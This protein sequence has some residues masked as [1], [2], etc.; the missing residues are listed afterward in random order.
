MKHFY[1]A[2]AA[3]AVLSL[4][5]CSQKI[6]I[7]EPVENPTFEIT[8]TVGSDDA[9]KTAVADDWSVSW[10]END[11]I[12]AAI[13]DKSSIKF[14]YS[15]G[16]KFTTTDFTAA[17]G[18][19][20]TWNLLYFVIGR[21]ITGIENGYN[22]STIRIPSIYGAQAVA[23]NDKTNIGKQPLYGYAT[24]TGKEQPTVVM[25]HL[26]SV[27]AVEL[28]NTG[29]EDLDITS[30]RLENDAD[31]TMSGN[32]Y[33]N[34]ADGSIKPAEGLAWSH[35]GIDINDGTLAGNT[36][37]TFYIPTCEFSLEAGNNITITVTD[38][39][40]KIATVVKPMTAATTFAAG[41]IKTTKFS[42]SSAD[43][44]EDITKIAKIT[45]G[46]TCTV[47]GTV[48]AKYAKGDVIS[49]ATGSVL[50]YLNKETSYKIGEVLKV[51]GTV[52]TYG[53]GIQFTNEATIT[54]EGNAEVTY[55]EP[56]VMDAAEAEKYINLSIGYCKYVSMI[57]TLNI[58]TSNGKT[59]YN[60]VIDGTT[61]AQGSI[62]Y[63][64]DEQ[65]TALSALNGKYIALKGYSYA[66]SSNKFVN[67]V[68]TEVSE[69]T[70]PVIKSVSGE[71]S[72][73]YD[74]TDAHTLTVEGN[75]LDGKTITVSGNSH[76]NVAVNG[77]TLTV[78]PSAALS[79]TD[80]EVV[81]T[82]TVAIEGGNNVAVKLTHKKKVSE[83]AAW[84][85]VTDA[86][87]LK[88]GDKIVI[89]TNAK[90]FVASSTI[91]SSLLTNVAAT[92]SDDKA[93]I[94]TLPDDAGIFT[95]GGEKDKWTLTCNDKKLGATAVK[96]MAWDSGTTTWTISI[97][98][99]DATIQSTTSTYG[100]I[101][102]NV[103]SPRFTTYTSNTNDSMLL[104]QIYR[105]E[106]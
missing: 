97:A 18:T 3:A 5:A 64:T 45:E 76:F 25:K 38:K 9:T 10:T 22:T 19:D 40:E 105:Y 82:V 12:S 46:L 58:S 27:I 26:T 15:G 70:G 34:C 29:S 2:T 37:A 17:D 35:A 79:D 14:S 72:W 99:N 80:D 87:T 106:E 94:T 47:K 81:E 30:I 20:Y 62:S 74:K 100:R 92:F 71:T 75:N 98:G 103:S 31:K 23:A 101:L 90:G 1:L 6:D 88:V 4:A 55:P 65:K 93:T 89:A 83:S 50:L 85:L 59:Y 68:M 91:S 13:N 32:F 66:A 63:P 39:N 96:K 43:F 8:A 60:V 36:T 49:D 16:N 54:S 48:V 102:Y 86:S 104:P 84:T 21:G 73:D 77:T 69:Y 78:T 7:N 28:T 57:G 11:E 42:L 95:L 52:G 61:S 51:K 53:N 33:V 24:T 44:K 41:K 56:V 67:I